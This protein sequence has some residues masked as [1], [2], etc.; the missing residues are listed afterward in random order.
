M[1]DFSK[2]TATV[3]YSNQP[4]Y[5]VNGQTVATAFAR[6]T[7][8]DGSIRVLQCVLLDL[9][10]GVGRLTGPDGNEMDTESFLASLTI[11]ADDN[12]VNPAVI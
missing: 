11:V 4:S 1:F 12:V 7:G 3:K 8:A 5:C 10:Q 9:L 2:G 6:S